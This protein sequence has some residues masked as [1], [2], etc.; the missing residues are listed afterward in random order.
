ML[1]ILS[2]GHHLRSWWGSQT[3]L[4]LMEP[5]ADRLCLMRQTWDRSWH[6]VLECACIFLGDQQCSYRGLVL[7]K[8]NHDIS[9]NKWQ[10]A[11]DHDSLARSYQLANNMCRLSISGD[12]R[13]HC[14]ILMQITPQIMSRTSRY[15]LTMAREIYTNLLMEARKDCIW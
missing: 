7:L 8:N 12:I 4:K 9:R 15:C 2:C 13:R 10:E 6:I 11:A 5:I 3:C 14:K 1:D